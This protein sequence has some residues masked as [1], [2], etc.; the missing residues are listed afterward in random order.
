MWFVSRLIQN[1]ARHRYV[2]FFRR[3]PS[4]SIAGIREYPEGNDGYSLLFHA[5]V[6]SSMYDLC[7]DS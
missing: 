7:V 6:A 2:N 5:G 1:S 4:S 3:R